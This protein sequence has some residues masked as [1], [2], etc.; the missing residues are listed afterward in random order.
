[1]ISEPHTQHAADRNSG[2][3]GANDPEFTAI[4]A[5]PTILG[6]I[7]VD[8]RG[9][10]NQPVALLWPSLFTDHRLW[11]A[12]VAGLRAAGWRTLALDPP[13]HGASPGPGRA[14]TMD[15]CAE[16]ALQ[17]LDVV[18]VRTPVVVLGTSWGGFVAP[19]IALRAPERVR[20]LIL[21][22][23]S[24]DRP[25]LFERVKSSLLTKL[26]AIKMIEGPV[27]RMLAATML[28][29]TTRRDQPQLGRDLARRLRTWSRRDVITTVRSVLVT[30]EA[31]LDQLSDIAV[32][33]LVVCGAE[34]HLLPPSHSHRIV[35]EIATS[36][37]V[38]VASA[39]HLVPLEH[40]ERATELVVDFVSQWPRTP[41]AMS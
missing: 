39:A 13:G 29:A 25:T 11:N 10:A 28:A 30:R 32:P 16:A 35:A 1:M 12:P 17:V 41:Y 33:T 4:R 3:L 23:T 15:E 27:D 26:M 5:V 7:H 34:D 2:S 40:P 24:A 8:D 31:V 22:N 37:L 18:G 20:G 9:Y 6:P 36:K 19:R 21:F 38:E 14:F